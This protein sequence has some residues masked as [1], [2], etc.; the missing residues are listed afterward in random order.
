MKNAPIIDLSLLT[1]RQMISDQG[2][3]L[4]VFHVVW[5]RLLR[6]SLVGLVWAGICIYAYRYLVPLNSGEL[7]VEQ[8]LFYLSGIACIATGFVLWMIASRVAHPFA[9]RSRMAKMLHRKAGLTVEPGPFAV[10]EADSE[11]PTSRIFVASHDSNGLIAA[12]T[13]DVPVART[14]N[15]IEVDAMSPAQPAVLYAAN[16]TVPVEADPAWRPAADPP[17]G[18]AT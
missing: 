4:G 18:V 12:L 1:P 10:M 8:L 15:A 7:P 16:W 11:R 5:Y 6:P 2:M 14:A 13:P 17:D 9:A 3:A